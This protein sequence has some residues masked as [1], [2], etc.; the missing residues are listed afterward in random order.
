MNSKINRWY[1]NLPEGKRFGVFAVVC[2]PPVMLMSS[3]GWLGG[4]SVIILALL[5]LSRVIWFHWS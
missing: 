3:G 1:D 2:L 4:V 5:T